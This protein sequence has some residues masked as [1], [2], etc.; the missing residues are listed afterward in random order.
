MPGSPPGSLPC[1][2]ASEGMSTRARRIVQRTCVGPHAGRTRG[3][4]EPRQAA[5]AHLMSVATSGGLPYI[6]SPIRNTLAANQMAAN[7]EATPIPIDSHTCH[8][9]GGV[10]DVMRISMVNVLTGGMKL[11]TVLKVE[12]GSRPIGWARIQGAI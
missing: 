12:L 4:V 3:P 6:S 8:I 10:T 7:A 11:M 2:R 1:R 9:G 5:R